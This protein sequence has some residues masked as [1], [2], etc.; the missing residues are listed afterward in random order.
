MIGN[1]RHQITIESYAS[2]GDGY[3][4]ATVT[5]STFLGPVWSEIKP[6]SARER[7][8][9]GKREHNVTHKIRMRYAAGVTS[10][11]RVVFGTRVFQIH[12][13]INPEE[14]NESLELAAEE[15]VGS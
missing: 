11:M 1:L 14:R 10:E 4:G 3:G 13:V 8:A 5:W 9:A 7:F 2:A 12:G 6:V 15:G